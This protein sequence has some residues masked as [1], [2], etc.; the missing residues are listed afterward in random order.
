MKILS[1]AIHDVMGHGLFVI[2]FGGRILKVYISII[3]PYDNSY[4]WFS[5][6]PYGFMDWQRAWIDGSGILVCLLTS[7]LMQIFLLLRWRLDW[8][9]ASALIWLSFWTLASSTGYLI[10]GGIQPFGDVANLI[11]RGILTKETSIIYG[12]TSLIIGFIAISIILGRILIM[13][14][15]V[16]S[17]F[18]L[19]KALTTFWLTIPAITTISIIGRGWPLTYIPITFIPPIIAYTITPIIWRRIETAKNQKE[20]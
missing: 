18:G 8:R 20:T 1:D 11:G 15:L 5:S 12:I 3:W 17:R 9:I 7:Y 10:M 2:L 16:K 4:I 13:N 19:E 14:G 6:P